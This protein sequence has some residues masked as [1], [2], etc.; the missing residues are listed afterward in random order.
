MTPQAMQGHD[1]R[2]NECCL[3]DSMKSHT[4]NNELNM[5][6]IQK[7]LINGIIAITKN[8]TTMSED[9]QNGLTCLAAANF[10]QDVNM[11]THQAQPE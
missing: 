7:L 10:E 2:Q 5:Q 4:R 1:N 11:G 9:E 6:K 3:W 8:M